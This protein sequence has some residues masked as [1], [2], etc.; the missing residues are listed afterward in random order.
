MIFYFKYVSR[1]E[2]KVSFKTSAKKTNLNIE[3]EQ[4]LYMH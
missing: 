4:K 1:L 2:K 3:K